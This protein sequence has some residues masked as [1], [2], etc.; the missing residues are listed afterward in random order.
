MTSREHAAPLADEISNAEHFSLLLEEALGGNRHEAFLEQRRTLKRIL[1]KVFPWKSRHEGVRRAFRAVI[2]HAASDDLL[3]HFSTGTSY[4]VQV[5]SRS[6]SAAAGQPCYACS[7]RPPATDSLDVLLHPLPPSERAALLLGQ[8][9]YATFNAPSAV[10]KSPR[11]Q[12][13]EE[14]GHMA[15]TVKERGQYQGVFRVADEAGAN[16]GCRYTSSD[17]GALDEQLDAWGLRTFAIFVDFDSECAAA[18]IEP[19]TGSLS[20]SSEVAR[21]LDVDFLLYLDGGA[22]E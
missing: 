8:A 18:V 13:R 4:S 15:V 10:P 16:E 5:K 14:F 7:D 2:D 11:K 6:T 22:S 19:K 12:D 9:K 3:I 20:H 17:P 1:E 21:A